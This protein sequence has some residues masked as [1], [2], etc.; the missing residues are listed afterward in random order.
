MNDRTRQTLLDAAVIL[1]CLAGA[2]GSLNLFR[3]DLFRAMKTHEPSVG[4]ITFK[5]NTAQRRLADRSLWD[6]LRNESPIYNGDLIRTAEMS[7][8]TIHIP[9]SGEIQLG[10][11]TLVRIRVI[12]GKNEIELSSGRLSL[13]S[14]ASSTGGLTIS[15]GENRLEASAGTVLNAEA[16]DDGLVVQVSEGSAV[17]TGAE[18]SPQAIS[19]IALDAAGA[20]RNEPA[21]VVLS[22]VPN[23]R[24]V[25]QRNEAVQVGFSWNRINLD[26][27]EVLRVEAAADKNY[28][29]IIHSLES[30]GTSAALDFLP[31]TWYWRIRTE[32]MELASG[33][34]SVA[35]VSAPSPL[36]PAS[37]AVYRYRTRLPALQ[38]QWTETEGAV[39]YRLEAADNPGFSGSKINTAVQGTFFESSNL[40]AGT[41]YWRVTPVFPGDY[42]GS[43][44]SSLASFRIEQSGALGVPVLLLPEAGGAVNAAAGR[45]LYFSWKKEN[46]A[47]SYTIR[48]ARDES[49][50]N[51]MINATVKSNFFVYGQGQKALEAGRYYWAVFQTDSE[52]SSSAPSSVRSFTAAADMILRAVFPPDNY[53]IAETL[54]P[55]FRFT[56]KSNLSQETRFQVSSGADFSSLEINE[57]VSGESFHGRSLAPGTWYWRVAAGTGANQPMQTAARRFTAMPIFPAPSAEI[58]PPNGQI[59]VTG[60]ET[61]AFSWQPIGGADY[62]QFR[63]YPGENRNRPVYEQSLRDSALRV[64]STLEEGNYYWTVQAFATETAAATRRTGRISGETFF[65]RKVR[66]VRLETPEENAEIPGLTALRHPIVVRWSTPDIV[67]RVRFIL[68]RSSGMGNPVLEIPNPERSIGLN[69]LEEG[70]YYWTISAETS[71]GFNIS[72]APRRFRV[73]P[74]SL[75][76]RPTLLLPVSGH[77]VGPEELRANRSI[78]FNWDKIEEADAYI[79]TLY[80]ETEK[81]RRQIFQT[82]PETGLSWTLDDLRILDKGTFF[83]QVEAI[84]IGEDGLPERRGLAGENSFTLDI[85]LPSRVQT[86][87]AGILYGR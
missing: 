60:E 77:I 45:D 6:R 8:A 7:E 25:S 76:P 9:E 13:A 12:N 30:T 38:F 43:V 73:L 56:W 57:V 54:L 31:G 80:Q 51:P 33:R 21:A 4:I 32:K 58:P 62:Y 68:S 79:L 47:E 35:Q 46:E 1:F 39:Q 71:E 50:Q 63:L 87:D 34:L 10:E 24:F 2:G 65:L 42:Q 16:G 55:D 74:I 20:V 82:G 81:G 59:A 28:T 29:Q 11:N 52:G 48:I 14:G 17:L 37:A 36:R 64:A 84:G 78:V 69:R 85:T 5:Y 18:G 61:V 53:A 3:L 22:P 40:G 70:V 72:A 41:W 44:E 26:D 75:L 15:I 86:E 27:G 83:W 67:G 23:A 49:L 19:F 66:P